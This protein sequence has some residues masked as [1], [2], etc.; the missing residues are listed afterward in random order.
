MFV[1]LGIFLV[2]NLLG[3]LSLHLLSQSFTSKVEL[4]FLA[5]AP[6]RLAPLVVVTKEEKFV[7]KVVSVKLELSA[8][9]WEEWKQ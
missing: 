4:P 1:Q 5:D 6:N 9:D 2:G 8:A 7:T 3:Y